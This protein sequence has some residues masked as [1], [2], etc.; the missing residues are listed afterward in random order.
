MFNDKYSLPT[1]KIELKSIICRA[2]D[3]CMTSPKASCAMAGVP[4]MVGR[5][6][7]RWKWR[8]N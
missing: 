3:E 5:G 8:G 6:Y 4:N 2:K 1:Q 7:K